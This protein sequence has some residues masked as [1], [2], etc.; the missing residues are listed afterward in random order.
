ML[1]DIIS[2]YT[3]N[4]FLTTKNKSWNS[5]STYY[6]ISRTFIAFYYNRSQGLEKV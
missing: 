6:E 2:F 4:T 3:A 5:Y 1:K